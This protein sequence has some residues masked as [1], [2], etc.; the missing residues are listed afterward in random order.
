MGNFLLNRSAFFFLSLALSFLV[1]GV[2]MHHILKSAY[3]SYWTAIDR[4]QTVDFNLLASTATGTVSVIIQTDNR[5]KAEEFVDSNYCLFRIQIERCANEACQVMETMA[6]NARNERARC[7]ALENG[8]QALRIPIFQDAAS[9]ATVS[10]NHAYSKQADVAVE[11]GQ[12]IG[13]LTLSRGSFIPFEA[14][15]KDFLSKWLK[16][17]ANAS[18]HEI[19]KTSASV[20]LLLGLLTF[21]ILFIVRQFYISQVKRKIITEKLLRVIDRKIENKSL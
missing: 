9:L 10:F 15:Y 14:D 13:Y 8:K 20:S 3:E 5:E 6:D 1:V 18:R 12:P 7:Q 19:Y 2:S 4:V 11:T 17:E 16:G 21:L